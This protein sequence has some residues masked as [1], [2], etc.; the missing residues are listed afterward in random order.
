MP[1]HPPTG[2][3]TELK[4]RLNQISQEKTKGVL[5]EDM[6]INGAQGRNRTGS[7]LIFEDHR[8]TKSN[9][10]NNLRFLQSNQLP[11]IPLICS[12]KRHDL[13]TEFILLYLKV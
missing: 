1:K 7:G 8:E 13:G 5:I 4:L 3:R 6:Q 2:V 12:V 10:N 9:K 11:S